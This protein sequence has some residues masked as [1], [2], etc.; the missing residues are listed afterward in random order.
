MARNSIAFMAVAV[1]AGFAGCAS[2]ARSDTA[3]S[4][5]FPYIPAPQA[6]QP[7]AGFSVADGP[8]RI[9]PGDTVEVTVL[10]APEL[11]RT[12]TVA[13]SGHIDLPLIAPV[14]AADLTTEELRLA[15]TTAYSSELRLPEIDVATTA[16]GSQQIFV[17]GEVT[18]PGAFDVA[19]PIDALQAVAL[20]GGFETTAR[21][22]EV[23]V[24][25]RPPGGGRTVQVIDLSNRAVREGLVRTPTLRR[26]DVVFVPRSRISQV[27]LFVQQY[28][29]D[30]LPIQF[31][32]F[33]D[34]AGNNGQN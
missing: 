6:S 14:L 23:I 32:L 12:V 5:P 17:G 11:S 19:G 24:I 21:R 15:L 33:Y 13:P 27:N 22:Q 4:A 31:S 30:A 25:S 18:T 1:A 34:L 9:Y 29:R 7:P 26:F 2:L 20:A 3:Q 16:F 10:S 8:Y 28:V